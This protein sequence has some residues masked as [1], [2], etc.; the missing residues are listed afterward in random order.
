MKDEYTSFRFFACVWKW[1]KD[2]FA[3][4]QRKQIILLVPTYMHIILN[5]SDGMNL[6]SQLFRD[7]MNDL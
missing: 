6:Y 5:A 1:N 4:W 7:S 3:I 2:F